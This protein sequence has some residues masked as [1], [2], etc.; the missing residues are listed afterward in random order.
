MTGRFPQRAGLAGNAGSQ[1]GQGGMPAEQ[2]T[3]AELLKQA[4]YVTGH[5]GKWHLGYTPETMPNAQGFRQSFGHMGGCIDNYSHFFYWSGP[6]RH[7]LWRNGEEVWAD[8]EFF[9]DLMVAECRKFVEQNRTRP[10]FLYW[11]I[12]VPHYPLQGTERWRQHYARL[13]GPRRMY[14]AFVSTMDERI[15]QVLN[16]LDQLGLQRR[17]IVIFQSDHGHSTEVRTF[18]GGGNA[19]PYRGAK[20]S[21]F[22]GGIR[23]PAM[24]SWPGT[25]PEGEVRDQLATGLDWFPTVA[26]LCDVP[27]PKR[28]LDGRS[29]V[30][31]IRSATAS[32]PHNVMHWQSGRGMKR[33]PQWA[34]REGD[35]KLL[36][37]PIDTSKTA[38][39]QPQDER[40]LINLKTDPGER[41]N[42][43]DQHPEIL[44]RLEQLHDQWLKDVTG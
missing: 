25:L 22:E 31:V 34:V 10:F 15:G 16:A 8:G 21:L 1:P 20:F 44:Q 9:P 42:L 41:R 24:I 3:L 11:A 27:L 30:P 7:D 17:T 33:R 14:A 13:P 12:N 2:L 37:N 5:V 32:T 19:G 4:G 26:E 39:L 35:W 40:M 23:V 43:R 18:G 29:L 36:G 38:P 28:R 6:N